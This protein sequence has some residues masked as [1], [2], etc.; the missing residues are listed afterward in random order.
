MT[1]LER[2]DYMSVGEAREY[3]GV[4]RPKMAQLIKDGV[5][6]AAVDPLNKRYKWLLRAQVEELKAQE[7]KTAA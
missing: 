4:S 3:L 1:T 7:K 2:G 5:L 6:S